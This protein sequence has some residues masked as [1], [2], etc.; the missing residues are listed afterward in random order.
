MVGEGDPRGQFM[1]WGG[2]RRDGRGLQGG[3]TS[4]RTWVSSLYAH[5]ARKA[6]EAQVVGPVLHVRKVTCLGQGG[7]AGGAK[8]ASGNPAGKMAAPPWQR[9]QGRGGR[10]AQEVRALGCRMGTVSVS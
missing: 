1:T 7:Q 6:L 5:S 8:T 2:Q 10:Q 9:F 3:I 4:G